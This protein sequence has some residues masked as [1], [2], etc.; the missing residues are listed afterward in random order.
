MTKFLFW[1]KTDLIFFSCVFC[2]TYILRAVN[3]LRYWCLVRNSIYS[4]LLWLLSRR[5]SREENQA[6][7]MREG[8]IR[9]HRT[10]FLR[11]II[12]YCVN[13]YQS[14]IAFLFGKVSLILVRK[15]L[16]TF[17]YSLSGFFSWTMFLKFLNNFL[18]KNE[19]ALRLFGSSSCT[20]LN[21]NVNLIY[22]LIDSIFDL[23]SRPFYLHYKCSKRV[24]KHWLFRVLRRC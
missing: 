21:Q 7:K 23:I 24:F 20:K 16:N 2:S 19:S 10:F 3:T 9:L 8:I 11:A 22:R 17:L 18:R 5:T 12:D 15:S 1:A 6:M 13:S 4:D 14:A